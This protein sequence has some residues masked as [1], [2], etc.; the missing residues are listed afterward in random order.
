MESAFP[1]HGKSPCLLTLAVVC[2]VLAAHQC[3][4]AAEVLVHNVPYHRQVTEYSC[5][6]ASMQMLLHWSG[7]D[8]DQRA[9]I[10][11][12]RTSPYE[13]TLRLYHIFVLIRT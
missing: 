7:A 4:E 13:G 8:I 9:I 2:F 3:V 5:G 12:M 1:C 11:V 6:D 10:D